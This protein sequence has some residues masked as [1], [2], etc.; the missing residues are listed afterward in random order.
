MPSPSALPAQFGAMLSSLIALTTGGTKVRQKR[1]ALQAYPEVPGF[2]QSA[3]TTFGEAE[4]SNASNCV[5]L[6]SWGS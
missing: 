4:R 6:F 3:V 2:G 5:S 1:T